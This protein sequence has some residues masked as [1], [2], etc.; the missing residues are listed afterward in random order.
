VVERAVLG[1][2]PG[3]SAQVELPWTPSGSS[4]TLRILADAWRV[5]AEADEA[6]ND[7]SAPW[8]SAGG[9]SG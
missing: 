1:L 4:H 2:E 9:A 6:N 8:T 7:R 5:V 3:A